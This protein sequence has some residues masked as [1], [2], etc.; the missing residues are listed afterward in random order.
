M[1]EPESFTFADP[2]RE[3]HVALSPKWL[4]AREHTR[5]DWHVYA[6]L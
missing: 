2:A 3:T 1:H 6:Q 5:D 4:Q